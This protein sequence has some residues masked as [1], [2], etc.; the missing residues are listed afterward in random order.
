MAV[1]GISL[2][3]LPDVLY[4]DG[5]RSRSNYDRHII[6]QRMTADVDIIVARNVKNC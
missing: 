5:W 1:V 4:L 6:A 3:E 2:C